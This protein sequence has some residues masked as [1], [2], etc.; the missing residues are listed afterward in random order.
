M[1]AFFQAMHTVVSRVLR[2]QENGYI[3]DAKGIYIK[4]TDADECAYLELCIV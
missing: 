2:C 1:S 4:S 3:V